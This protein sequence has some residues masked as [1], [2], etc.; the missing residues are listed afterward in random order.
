MPLFYFKKVQR[1]KLIGRELLAR[2]GMNFTEMH[3][4]SHNNNATH[5]YEMFRI[6]KIMLLYTR[7]G[8]SETKVLL[9]IREHLDDIETESE[10]ITGYGYKLPFVVSQWDILEKVMSYKH[11]NKVGKYNLYMYRIS[12][13]PNDWLLISLIYDSDLLY[14]IL[15]ILINAEHQADISRMVEH[16]LMLSTVLK[17]IKRNDPS[18]YKKNIHPYI[19]RNKSCIRLAHLNL[20][21]NMTLLSPET[22]LLTFLDNTSLLY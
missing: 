6:Q 2:R 19:N 17:K 15:N 1:S 11:K 20:L 14:S 5:L 4:F 8:L 22:H 16:I 10:Y 9:Y 7:S 3:T 18:Y 12:N 21:E 13:L